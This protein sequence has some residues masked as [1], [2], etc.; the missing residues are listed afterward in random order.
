M[1]KKLSLR[2]QEIIEMS[3]QRDFLRLK[4]KQIM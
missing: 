4:G 1:S 2:E 3:K